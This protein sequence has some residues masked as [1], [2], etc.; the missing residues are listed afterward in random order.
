MKWHHFSDILIT[1]VVTGEVYMLKTRKEDCK[2]FAQGTGD[3][4]ETGVVLPDGK[5]GIYC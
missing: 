5:I 4:S 1:G 2:I 3:K